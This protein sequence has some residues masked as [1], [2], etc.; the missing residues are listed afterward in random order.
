M[1]RWFI[2]DLHFSHANIIAFCDRPFKDVDEMNRKIVSN[3]NELVAPDD[4]LWILGDIAMGLLSSSLPIV[5]RI[6]ARK[7]L[8]AGNHDRC[9]PYYGKKSESFVQKYIDDTNAEKLYT[10]NTTLTLLDGTEVAVSHFPYQG[11]SDVATKVSRSG[12]KTEGDKFAEY[13]VKNEG[14][15]LVCGHVH[16]KWAVQDKQINVGIDAWGGYPVSEQTL[17]DI[18]ASGISDK[19]RIVWK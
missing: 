15:W 17:V 13:R 14:G 5:K 2:S 8:V 3:I 4:E 6:M 16:E 12:K 18:I 11:R 7:I 9:H 1:A 19:P 10:G